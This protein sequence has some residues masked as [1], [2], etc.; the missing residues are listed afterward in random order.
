MW[1]VLRRTQKLK[2]A[3]G[4]GVALG[5]IF[6]VLGHLIAFNFYGSFLVGESNKLVLFGET[7]L[8]SSG[9]Y[10]FLKKLFREKIS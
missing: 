7:A 8:V 10:F 9:L 1:F 6:W 4:V 5:C 3:M 2:E